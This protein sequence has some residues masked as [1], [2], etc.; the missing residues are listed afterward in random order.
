MSGNLDI[1]AVVALGAVC[2]ACLYSLVAFAIGFQHQI[3]DVRNRLAA[4]DLD[5]L[6][7]GNRLS[8][9]CL[10]LV[11]AIAHLHPFVVALNKYVALPVACVPPNP[12]VD[13]PSV[14]CP[15][16]KPADLSTRCAS[17]DTRPN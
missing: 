14:C 5:L 6:V 10:Q 7:G 13:P 12:P 1:L 15:L 16:T 4:A 17:L 9:V 8:A 2:I 11:V 3:A